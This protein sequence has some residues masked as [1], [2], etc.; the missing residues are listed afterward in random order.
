M[1]RFTALLVEGLRAGTGKIL[2]HVRRLLPGE[3]QIF[4][5]KEDTFNTFYMQLNTQRFNINISS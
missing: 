3:A 4:P 1:D 2:L 5:Y